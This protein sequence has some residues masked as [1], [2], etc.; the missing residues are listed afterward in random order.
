MSSVFKGL[1][2]V[3]GVVLAGGLAASA[4]DTVPVDAESMVV[5]ARKQKEEALKVPVSVDA[6]SGSTL[7]DAGV[8][9][10]SEL[11]RLSPN[12]Y[13]K[14]STFSNVPVIRGISS[15]DT[16][17]YGPVGFYV[18]DVSYPMHFAHNPDFFD[19]ERVEILKGP[20]G[21][22]YGRNS[23][24]GV[25]SIIT[26]KPDN[27]FRGSLSGDVMTYDTAEGDSDGQRL[28]G[29]LSGAVVKD[30]LYFGVAGFYEE[31]DGFR[32]NLFDEGANPDET[33]R[34]NM[35]P[36]LRWTP[37]NRWDVTLTAEYARADDN[38]AFY[39]FFTG[40]ARTDRLD[41]DHNDPSYT[42]Q[43]SDGQTL[44]AAYE[45][46]AFTMVSVTG[47]RRY[48]RQFSNDF[49]CT[50]KPL[51]VNLF[52][53]RND[54]LSQELRIASP[55]NDS[56]LTW[57]GGVY[58]FREDN[59]VD[60][61]MKRRMALRAS[62]RHTETTLDGMALFGQG[63]ASVTDRLRLTA[64][65]RVDRLD[66]EGRQRLTDTHGTRSY[67]RDLDATELLPKCSLAFDLTD[68]VMTYATC[69]RGYLAG[70]YSY[71]FATGSDTLTYEPE[72]TT[73]YE[74]G[75]K[76]SWLQERL[77]AELSLFYIEMKDKQIAEYLPGGARQINNA[78]R[79]HSLGAE[80]GLKARPLRGMEL[81]AGLGYTEA[82]IDRWSTMESAGPGKAPARYDYKDNR[83][84]NVPETT[85]NIG[86]Q[87]LAGNGLFARAD[88]FGTGAF[89]FDA[90]NR[91]KES[92]YRLVNLRLGYYGE[93]FDLTLWGKNIFDEEYETIKIDWLGEELGQDGTPR[94]IGAS[95]T[96]RF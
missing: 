4:D 62:A 66:Q 16:S 74:A 67:A 77:L 72:F 89:Y 79:A 68:T 82:R 45:G 18:N 90:K 53:L 64:G 85:Y 19:I 1:V 6:F 54:T 15:F 28:R 36:S 40:P 21:T 8:A 3:V 65:L 32:T 34:K 81:S 83:L 63:T 33:C 96:C 80:L 46:D 17:L 76:S 35:R 78:A 61:V 52:D 88:L 13:M 38:T 24:S 44:R 84:P 14:Y 50:S 57:L 41:I 59:E 48:E 94:Q 26:R 37:T 5:T 70:G 11:T 31:S 2:L 22:L 47:N 56:P 23:E 55:D 73:N 29:N 12:V 95:V 92:P 71:N 87:Y 93:T 75:V 69:S 30:T 25:I 27:T 39:R 10:T 51:G 43:D 58:A 42:K 20:Q 7:A 9:N 60:F 49:D 91:L 86:A